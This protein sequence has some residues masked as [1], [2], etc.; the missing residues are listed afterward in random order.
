M[1]KT[2]FLLTMAL[3][4]VVLG[5][6]LGPNAD[7]DDGADA[8]PAVDGW[9]RTINILELQDAVVHVHA[10]AG[11]LSMVEVRSGAAQVALP[12]AF[13]VHED[14]RLR[15]GDATQYDLATQDNVSFLVT[16]FTESF[17]IHL[18][19]TGAQE[20]FTVLSPYNETAA[21]V[22]GALVY[23]LMEVQRDEFP[24]RTPGMPNYEKSQEYFAELFRGWGYETVV[25]DEYG[26]NDLPQP[27]GLPRGIK[28]QS[29]ANVYA[30]RPGTTDQIVAFGGH[31]DAVE[32]TKEA[33]FDDTSGTVMTLALA[34]A[35]SKIDTDVGLLF[36]LWGG[37]EDGLL[38][39]QFFV[40]SKPDLVAKTV[41]YNNLDVA[42]M[43]WPGPYENPTPMIVA[44][45][46]DGPVS[47]ALTAQANEV[48]S[49]YVPEV[50]Q[51]MLIHETVGAGQA[52][53]AGVNAQ[54]DHTPF[55]S[56]GVPVYFPFTSDVPW[57]R[58][59]IHG[60]QDTLH[61]MTYYMGT[62]DK[63]DVEGKEQPPMTAEEEERG[64]YLNMRSFEAFLALPFYTTLELDSGRWTSPKDVEQ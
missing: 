32:N 39:S 10:A 21:L 41:L 8:A 3:V 63:F 49:L 47:D 27:E 30:Y 62:G 46:P 36:G 2:T 19:T 37:E 6:C 53:G 34:E 22:N 24:H 4:T 60:P 31:Y 20:T 45:G 9:G 58:Q 14:G 43:A 40:R 44:T 55:M 61:N 26:L 57:A 51:D 56:A 38:G 29:M 17:E 12:A 28:P 35:F 54:S 48:Y 1:R 16:P 5:G 59:F 33:A 13:W 50:P 42:A 11:A 23:E 18:N 25:V 15:E 7:D 52:V 64:R